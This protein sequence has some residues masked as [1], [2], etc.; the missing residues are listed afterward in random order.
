MINFK[1]TQLKFVQQLV[2][3]PIEIDIILGKPWLSDWNPEIDWTKNKM[4]ISYEGQR[5]RITGKK[6]ENLN[7]LQPLSAMMLKNY[8]RKGTVEAIYAVELR[9]VDDSVRN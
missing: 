4:D 2:V 6:D 5:I 9:N 8:L 3:V 7:L 1:G